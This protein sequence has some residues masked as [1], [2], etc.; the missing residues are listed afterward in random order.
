MSIGLKAD[1]NNTSGAIQ[2]GGIDKVIVTN[3][4]D[5]AATTFT[6]NLVGN[7]DTAT[8]FASTTG[9]APVYGVRAWVAF[10]PTKD[11]TGASN[12]NATAR[13]I[14]SSGNVTSVTKTSGTYLTFSLAFTTPLPAADYVVTSGVGATN[15]SSLG[16]AYTPFLFVQYNGSSYV[17]TAPTTGGFVFNIDGNNP[18]TTTTYFS[19]AVIG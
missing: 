4:G 6:G 2:I 9:T 18:T 13:Y 15:S 16:A 1:A 14:H 3:A 5:V 7:A 11:S 17:Y 10:D 19:L 8:K 12:Y